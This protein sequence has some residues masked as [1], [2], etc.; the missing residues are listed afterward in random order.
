MEEGGEDLFED[1]MDETSIVWALV[2]GGKKMRAVLERQTRL[3][4]D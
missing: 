3:T 4:W 2:G 1:C